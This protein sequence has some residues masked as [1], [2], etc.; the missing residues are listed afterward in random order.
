M[1]TRLHPALRS[2]RS[3]VWTGLGAVLVAMLAGA[4]S[5]RAQ[6]STLAADRVT[7]DPAKAITQYQHRTWSTREGL[8]QN[9]ILS[10]VQ[11]TDGYVW[12]GT[13][14]GLAR[15][16]GLHFTVYD[17]ANTEALTTSNV[18]RMLAADDG[19]LWLAT[20]GG[21][22]VAHRAGQFTAYT[23]DDGLGS[24][25]VTALTQDRTGALWVGTFEG[26]LTRVADSTFATYGAEAG[27]DVRIVSQIVEDNRGT[28]W[29]GTEQGLRVQNG[30]RFVPVA[31][32]LLAEAFVS[33]LYEDADGTLWIGTRDGRLFSLT[34]GT[35]TEHPIPLTEPGQYV[36][37]F[38]EDA[39]GTLWIG[40]VGGL[41]R[42]D[43]RADTPRFDAFGRAE[44]LSNDAVFALHEDR[45]GGLWIGTQDGLNRLQDTKFTVLT[46]AEGL[47]HDLALAVYE[48]AAGAL[49]VATQGGLARVQ[50]GTVRAFTEADGLPSAHPLSLDGTADGDL[51][52]GTSGAGAA[53]LQDDAV[54][55]FTTDDGLAGTTV[56]AVYTDRAGTAWFATEAGVSTFDGAAFTTLPDSI[57]GTPFATAFHEDAENHLWIGTYDAG[58]V[59]L[60]PAEAGTPRAVTRYGADE[61]LP[62]DAVLA[63]HEDATGALWIGT[64]GGGLA[65]YRPDAAAGTPQ[66]DT[67]GV[68]EGLPSASVMAVLS[69]DEA[70]WL[71]SNRGVARITRASLDDHAFNPDAALDVTLYGLADGLRSVEANGGQQPAAW[72]A[73]DGTFWFPTT[74]GLAGIS[75]ARIRRNTLPPTVAVEALRVDGADVPVGAP[76]ALPPGSDKI[77][78][79]Y[80]APSFPA[81]ETVRFRF[82]LDG[83]DDAWYDAGTRREAYY[84]N[85]GPGTYEL[86]IQA[87][88][89]DGVWSPVGTTLAFQVAPFF[90][91][92]GWFLVVCVLLT[93]ALAYAAYATRVARLKA[94][95]RHLE[96][97]VDE[98]TRALREE[99]EKV[100]DA[101]AT[102]QAQ[103]DQLRELDRFK[104]R[105][106][107]NISHEFRTPLTL[108]LGPLDNLLGGSQGPLATPVRTQLGIMQRNAKRLL[109]LINQ[110]L[111]L[112][113]LESGRM[114][115]R[116]RPRNVVQL[117]EGIVASFQTYTEQKGIAL[118]LD[119][120]DEAVWLSYEPD[121]L[122]KVVFNLL[123]NAV[124]FTPADGTIAVAVEEHPANADAPDGWVHLRVTDTGRGIPP[125]KLPLIFDRFR[126]VED[127]DARE[128]EGSGIGLSMVHE[129]VQLHRGEI[130]VE[131]TVGEGT[132]FTVR[133][134]KGT[135][136]FHPDEIDATS[137]ID[138]D[139][140]TDGTAHGLEG[141]MVDQAAP[142][143][144][145]GMVDDASSPDVPDTG[146]FAPM[147]TPMVTDPDAPTVLIVDDNADIRAY[148]ASCLAGRYHI[149]EA[150]DGLDGLDKARALRPD[151]IV[152][153]IMMPRLDGNGFV[154]R[155]KT[156]DALRHIPVILL[157]A[158]TSQD[159]IETGL[160]HG[161]DEY[162]AK[163]FSARELLLR[164]RN[165]RRLRDQ[166]RA[167]KQLNDHLEQRVQDQVQVI[168]RE[169]QANVEA[170]ETE[171]AR[172]EQALAFRSMLMDNMSHEFRTPL[173]SIIGYAEIL[174][175][176]TDAHLREFAAFILKGGRRLLRTLTAL[177]EYA[178]I[179]SETPEEGGLLLA[180]NRETERVTE[181]YRA[182][183]AQR[184]LRLAL[185]LPTTPAWVLGDSGALQFV[186]ATLLDNAVKF[187][188][189]GAIEVS[190]EAEG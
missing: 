84:T 64:M 32:L 36:K 77:E 178:R 85:L 109:R 99:K 71:T 103:A 180:L 138:G 152:S 80:T 15:F 41:F 9:S 37:D 129:L 117:A 72:A 89:N 112:A 133:L 114:E 140:S 3:R 65:R 25:F 76:I 122:E 146:A 164:L 120:P 162:L 119:T 47:P 184:G 175:V 169:R 186:L 131:S 98:R 23:Q 52:V 67:F 46:P 176:E 39:E 126:Q 54:R 95:Q 8:P 163:P 177:I 173:T 87:A 60:A 34:G 181:H 172:T 73:R 62:A 1:P 6:T 148:I 38:V 75:P 68:A 20:R 182:Q 143:E 26:G 116:A 155:L 123:S 10:I 63:L 13:Q 167:L 22:L 158:K 45:E 144:A 21:G 83:H 43:Q 70:V 88:N 156:D 92:T 44:G 183:A 66:F 49:W 161:A 86:R 19:T 134:K 127:S 40:A 185:H 2:L 27:L 151:I 96:Q 157:S 90:W 136:H 69:T 113:R 139:E 33:A 130:D 149:G 135:A 118:T 56:F 91:Q 150:V 168:L 97:V 102:I 111:D 145:A 115:L 79:R 5:G 50:G 174:E 170:L 74:E 12:L 137:D 128:H 190:V 4:A 147:D 141:W 153:D 53:L 42:Y 132:T 28:L 124:K 81:P 105:F 17:E 7:L 166:E 24:D 165:L 100:E 48:D 29:V 101:H 55:V 189:A 171:K 106:F 51:W 94:R 107:A 187:T 93:L 125:E 108:M 61:G 11:T 104:T 14:E 58:L 16:D 179:E 160:A 188:E 78:V 82:R 35:R 154:Q 110:L 31:D 142:A 30:D 57:L 18:N 59:R 121:K 159:T